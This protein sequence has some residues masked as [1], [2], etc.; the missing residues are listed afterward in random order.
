MAI[1][2]LSLLQF[3]DRIKLEMRDQ[4]GQSIF[5]AIEQEV[6]PLHK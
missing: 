3:G 6:A 4:N 2:E 1:L 5:G